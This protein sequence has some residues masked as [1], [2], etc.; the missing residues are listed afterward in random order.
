MNVVKEMIVRLKD[1]K[2]EG[3]V[4]DLNAG[5]SLDMAR[6]EGPVCGSLLIHKAGANVLI[7]GTA[8]LEMT[9]TCS[10]CLIE[11]GNNLEVDINLTYMPW[12]DEDTRE[13]D[14]Q[15]TDMDI[16][17]YIG[18]EIDIHQLVTE[19]ILLTMPMKIVCSDT[20]LGLCPV[21]GLN[22]NDGQCRCKDGNS[23]DKTDFNTEGGVA[24]YLDRLRSKYKV[25]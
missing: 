11:F 19:Q 23:H 15:E 7:S 12:Q 25:K 18:E 16:G 9:L 17:F 24:S 20:C 8:R 6:V 5:V 4:V 14:L 22:L 21:C 2:E 13:Y 3:L 10:R 1:I